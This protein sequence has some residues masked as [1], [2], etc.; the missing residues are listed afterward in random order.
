MLAMA[1]C[2]TPVRLTSLIFSALSKL[3]N[4]AA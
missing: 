3:S 2:A 1:I 4:R